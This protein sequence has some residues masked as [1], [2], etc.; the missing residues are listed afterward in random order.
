[1]NITTTVI[2][3]AAISI[4]FSAPSAFARRAPAKTQIAEAPAPIPNEAQAREAFKK[5]VDAFHQKQF[6]SAVKYLVQVPELGGY[7]SLYKHWFLGQAYLELGKYAESEPEFA[8]V[9][10]GQA[11]SE[12]KYQAQFNLGEAALRQKKYAETILR[13]QPLER[14][15]RSSHRYPEVL[16]RLML[17]DLRLNRIAN[18]CKRA[19]K[20]YAKYPAHGSVMSWGSELHEVQIEGHRLPCGASHEDFTNRMRSLQWAGEGEKALKELHDLIAKTDPK[21]RMPLELTL[22]NFLVN[23]GHVE[24]ALKILIRYYPQEKTNLRFLTLLG[25]AAARAGE[26]QMAVGAYEKAHN[27]SPNSRKGREA[28]FQAAYLSYQFQDY[29]GAVRKFQEFAKRNPHSGLSRDA[30]WHLAWL[31]YLRSDY[32]GALERFAKVGQVATRRK[33]KASD[34][35]QDRLLYWTAMARIRLNEFNE[36]KVALDAILNRNRFSY[37]GLAAQARLE[38]IKPKIVENKVHVLSTLQLVPM[39]GGV[40]QD[41]VPAS[42]FVDAENE[43]EEE[44]TA[45][46]DDEVTPPEG[47]E[48]GEEQIQASDFKDPALRARIEVAQ[49]LI[50][51]GLPELARWELI[52]VERRTR[53][54]QFL[55]MLISAYEGISSYH[56]SASIAELAFV[57]DRENGGLDGAQPL[58]LSMFPQAYKPAVEG[59]AKRFSVPQEWIWAIMRAESLYRTDVISP[60]GAKGLMQLMPFTAR[61]LYKVSGDSVPDE[62]DLLNADVNIR[63]GTQYLGRLGQKF[64]SQLALVA[65]AYNAGPHRVESW[66]VNFGHLEADEFVEH[67][68]FLETRNYVKKVVRNHT[69]YR[70][71]YA[72]DQEPVGF[73]AKALGVP[74]PSRASPRETWENL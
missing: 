29:D 58:W 22:A 44:M 51:L 53:N 61:N 25:K 63:L 30:Q 6:D 20:L 28:L 40:T 68:P 48:E 38:Q 7:L 50:Q 36:A 24:E 46:A 49:K 27:L 65:A 18:A 35:L 41:A 42:K 10:Q 57:R 59:A 14:K 64:S 33:R 54:R 5:G 15:W 62:L 31:Q 71:L 8:K 11:S 4:L 55:R 32:R 1:M 3:T 17:A 19:R 23:D 72:K 16:Y 66:L 2:T 69:L 26:Y 47:E 67:I 13:L 52:E 43:S 39:E 56:R 21:S 9:I 12:L 70:R 60:V 37:Y 34:A 73:L 45:V 74:I